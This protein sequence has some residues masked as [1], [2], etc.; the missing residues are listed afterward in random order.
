MSEN[1]STKLIRKPTKQKMTGL[2][3]VFAWIFLWN[4][5][6]QVL[7]HAGLLEFGGLQIVNWAFFL[8]VTVY[9]MQEELTHEQRFFHT[10]V[11]GT[12]GLLIGA[13]IT[14]FVPVLMK[15]GLGK[16]PATC[17][18]LAVALGLLIFLEPVLPMFFNN[19]GFC[20]FIVSHVFTEKNA[21]EMLPS[22][23]VSLVLGSICLNLGCMFL[24]K[25]YGKAVAKKKAKETALAGK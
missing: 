11:G 7:H 21:V 8:S 24:L 14:K 19:V 18:L 20:Y 17:L 3:I 9:F 13:G 6:Y 5:I 4:V 22:Y 25:A 23:I 12:V 15:T 1:K 10:L 16:L 2:A